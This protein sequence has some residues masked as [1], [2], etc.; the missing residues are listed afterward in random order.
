MAM[1]GNVA[2][3]KIVTD[4]TAYLTPELVSKYD[5]QVVPLSVAF[6]K[7]SYVEGVDIANEEFYQ[8]LRHQKSSP[9]TSEPPVERFLKVYGE[10]ADN[11]NQVLSIHLSGKLSATVESARAAAKQLHDR[12]IEVVDSSFAAMALGMVVLAAGK[13][14]DEGQSLPDIKR[15]TEDV[16]KN[17]RFLFVVDTLKYL[18]EAGH[19]GAVTALFDAVLSPKPVFGFKDGRIEQMAGARTKP[20]AAQ[21][22]LELMEKHVSPG[23]P[24]HVA[25]I[26]AQAFDEAV[27]LE[28]QVRARFNC[29]EFYFSEVGPVIGANVGPGMT[30]LAFY[31]ECGATGTPIAQRQTNTLAVPN[32]G[33]VSQGSLASRSRD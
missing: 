6:G 20:K 32:Q 19:L 15:A 9:K 29:R 21:R 16:I 33:Q 13:A 11:V 26:H 5:V 12:Q 18:R 17:T 1:G 4:S 27:E 10:V 22:M 23:A 31:C 3:V 30:G 14:A 2:R 25:V 8:K 7:D 28:R 24:V